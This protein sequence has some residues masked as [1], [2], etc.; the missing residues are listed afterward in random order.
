VVANELQERYAEALL[1]RISSDPNP[2]ATHMAIFEAIATPRL[3]VAYT[4]HLME[5]IENDSNPSVPL[6]KRVQR[7]IASFG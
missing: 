1:D 7:L 5:R 3:L 4:V 6:M 2:S